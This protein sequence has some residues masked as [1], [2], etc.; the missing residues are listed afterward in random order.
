MGSR[1]LAG[2]VIAILLGGGGYFAYDSS[3]ANSALDAANRK[4]EASRRDGDRRRGRIRELEESL[5]RVKASLSSK[6]EE[7]REEGRKLRE[8]NSSLGGKVAQLEGEVRRLRE[9]AQAARAAEKAAAKRAEK[10][11]GLEK[12]LAAQKK[13]AGRLAAEAKAAKA[14]GEGLWKKAARYEASMAALRKNLAG[15]FSTAKEARQRLARTKE[16]VERMS[17]ERK[18]TGARVTAL[19]EKARREA[20]RA[21]KLEQSLASFRRRFAGQEMK[22]RQT[23]EMLRIDIVDRLLFGLGSARISEEGRG[24]LDRVAALLKTQP[25]KSVRVEGHTDSLPITGALAD[26]F[27]TNW[28]LSAARAISVVRHLES[29]G[30]APARLSATGYSSHHP[31]KGNET[32]AGRAQNRRIVIFLSLMK[33]PR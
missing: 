16:L 17:E 22:V 23:K 2:V 31:V 5:Q 15:S 30:V 13:E 32:A 12:D 11:A 6:T 7:V 1:V 25:G 21:A 9:E 33:S 8:E 26:R 18:K 19:E 20:R 27:S 14:E 4:L 29:K 28:E 10:A 3:K 24:A